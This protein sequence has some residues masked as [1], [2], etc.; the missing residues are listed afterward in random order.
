MTVIDVL[1]KHNGLVGDVF[2][3]EH[4][5]RLQGNVG[6]GHCR[7]PTAGSASSAEA[8]PLYVNSPYGI[9]LA[10]NG[11]LTNTDELKKDLFRENLRHLNTNS[12]SE[13]LLNVLANELSTMHALNPSP[14]ELFKA[15]SV[16]H[17]RCRGAYAVV[18]MVIGSG[19]LGFR[20][21]YGIRPLMYG[22]RESALGTEYMIA[23]ESVA[24]D[25]LGFN[26]IADVA[27]GEAIF[28]SNDGQIHK[29]KCATDTRLVPCIF[30]HVYFARPDS[31]I[32]DISVYKAV[33][34]WANI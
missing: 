29:H 28:I 9:A 14:S 3:E 25:I 21:P 24:L 34:A 30:E 10:H 20:D 17:E 8:Q 6:L 16:V 13:V 18:A 2:R 31:I 33:C 5:A 27:P 12:D 22:S 23:S 19:I 1:R 15:V 11:N 32:D 26:R 7:Y 4:M